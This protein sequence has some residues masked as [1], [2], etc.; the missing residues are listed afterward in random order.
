MIT[1]ILRYISGR[2]L[3]LLLVSQF[4]FKNYLRWLFFLLKYMYIIEKLGKKS[5]ETCKNHP[6]PMMT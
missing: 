6:F 5:K 3:E 2:G 4:F 1:E